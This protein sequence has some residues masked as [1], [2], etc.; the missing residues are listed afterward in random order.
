MERLLEEACRNVL[1]TNK[2]GDSAVCCLCASERASVESRLTASCCDRRQRPPAESR[3]VPDQRAALRI[4]TSKSKRRRYK[5]GVQAAG[6]HPQ[7]VADA[8]DQLEVAA[9]DEVG[10]EIRQQVEDVKRHPAD[11]EKPTP[12]RSA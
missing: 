1:Q 5:D 9:G 4:E 12:R 7:E 8:V 3:N 11:G 6:Q 10:A 2:H